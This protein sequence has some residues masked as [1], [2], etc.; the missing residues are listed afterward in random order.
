M[1]TIA[2][3]TMIGSAVV[4]ATAFAGG[5]YIFHL[6]ESGNAAEERKRHDVALETLNKQ[7]ATWNEARAR[8][9]DFLAEQRSKERRAKSDFIDMKYALHQYEKENRK[10]VLSDFYSP[11]EKQKK[12]EQIYVAGGIVSSAAIGNML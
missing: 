7:T 5:S 9:I 3:A 6:I 1:A 11:S 10:P 4:N 2:L 8:H 12:Y